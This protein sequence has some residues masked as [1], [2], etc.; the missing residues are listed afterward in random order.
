VIKKIFRNFELSEQFYFFDFLDTIFFVV[1]F[2]D[3]VILLCSEYAQKI[4]L[5]NNG[6]A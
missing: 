1:D 2:L 6:Y 5:A 3:V 4:D